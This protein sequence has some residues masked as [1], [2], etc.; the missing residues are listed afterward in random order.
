M[1]S[2]KLISSQQSRLLRLLF[3]TIIINEAQFYN[4]LISFVWSY[5]LWLEAF[6]FVPQILMFRAAKTVENYT[7]RCIAWLGLYRLL[8]IVG[9]AY[10][11]YMGNYASLQFDRLFLLCATECTLKQWSLWLGQCRLQCGC[12]WS[13]CTFRFTSRADLTLCFR[14]LI[15]MCKYKCCCSKSWCSN[16]F[17]VKV[18]ETCCMLDKQSLT[19][20]LSICYFMQWLIYFKYL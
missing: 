3:T 19:I 15:T 16:L 2:L 10:S 7:P 8:Y 1:H 18:I 14:L 17:G 13:L 11:S 5:S 12:E 9:W 20:N 4:N 6:A